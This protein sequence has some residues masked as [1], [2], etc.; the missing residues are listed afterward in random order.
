MIG[1]YYKT[2]QLVGDV[3]DGEDICI[4]KSLKCENGTWRNMK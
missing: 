3:A 2:A 1:A 4:R